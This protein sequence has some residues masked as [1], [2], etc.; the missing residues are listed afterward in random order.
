MTALISGVIDVWSAAPEAGELPG[1][2]FSGET[3]KKRTASFGSPSQILLDQQ[4][5]MTRVSI[6]SAWWH[7]GG[8]L[9]LKDQKGA[10]KPC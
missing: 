2:G 3:T 4:R 6:G 5:S 1:F 7:G 10:E 9:R 8:G